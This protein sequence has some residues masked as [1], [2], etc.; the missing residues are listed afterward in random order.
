MQKIKLNLAELEVDSFE[1]SRSKAKEG[2]VKGNIQA[3][4]FICP[5]IITCKYTCNCSD[6]ECS[7]SNC[8]SSI[9]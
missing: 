9:C 1:T 4:E 2:T 6:L 7:D 3:S 5:T 8:P